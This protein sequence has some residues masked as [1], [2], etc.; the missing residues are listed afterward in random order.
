MFRR[1]RRKWH[2]AEDEEQMTRRS[3]TPGVAARR[4]ELAFLQR[5]IGNRAVQ[6]MLAQ[7][8]VQSQAEKEKKAAKAPVEAG[9]VKIEPPKIEYYDVTG[10]S[11]PE[12][13]R[14]LLPKGKWYQYGYR[15]QIKAEK[16]VATRADVIVTITLRLP[17]WSGLGWEQAPDF[18]KVEWLQML[19][20]L[21]VDQVRHQGITR[22]PQRW[23]PGP[24]WE[25]TP[26][27]VKG[28]WRG[29]LQA[30]QTREQGCVDIARRR[31]L[32]LQ[33]RLFNQPEANV[34]AIFDQFIKDLKVE[35]EAYNRQ[36]EFGQENISVGA[37]VIVQ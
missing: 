4:S 25:K 14:Q 28:E 3:T 2:G 1:K 33:Q 32:V 18:D 11:L 12:V 21:D 20:S 34:K 22:L 8:Q 9:E 17:R 15:Y 10:D 16:G 5:Q 26:D 6:R 30:L 23:L 36:T 27:T 35:Q 29:M 13:S 19:Q 24:G 37:S 7:C 31:A